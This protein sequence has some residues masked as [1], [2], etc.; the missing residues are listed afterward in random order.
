MALGALFLVVLSAFLHAAWNAAAK[1][2]GA[3]AAFVFLADLTALVVLMPAFFFFR[4]ADLTPEVW[5]MVVAT[6][7]IHGV[8]AWSLTRAYEKGDLTLVYPI[9]RSTPA[10]VPFLAVPLLGERVS[11]AGGF[12]IALVMIGMWMVSTNARV[13]GLNLVTPELRFAYVTLAA[14]VAYSL[15]DKRAM[16]LLDA[17]PWQGPA[18]RA[19]AYYALLCVSYLPFFFVFSRRRLQLG[20]LKATARAR[21]LAIVSVV[22]ASFVSYTLILQALRTAPV[23]YVVA[24]RQLSVVFAVALALFWLRERPSRARIVGALLTV[25]GVATIGLAGA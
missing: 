10:F 18:P 21:P 1:G 20:S 19:V 25:V 9:S 4:L 8:Y 22:I 12:G 15:V 2:S 23:S 7:A 16:A 14:T 17:N 11:L 5:L 13:A 24:T 3:P 6:G